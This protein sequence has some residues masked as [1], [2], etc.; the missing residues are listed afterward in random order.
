MAILLDVEKGF[1]KV[2]H[3]GLILKCTKLGI[4]E[5]TIGFLLNYLRERSINIKLNQKLLTLKLNHWKMIM[6]LHYN[7][8]NLEDP[9]MYVPLTP[10]PISPKL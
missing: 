9:L 6:K 3:K 5:S 4:D 8:M 10:A 7:I 2:W 1:D